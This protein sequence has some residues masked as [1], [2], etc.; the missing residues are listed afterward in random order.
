MSIRYASRVD[1][2]GQWRAVILDARSSDALST[3]TCASEAEA[4][5]AQQ[6][7][8]KEGW[9]EF[10]AEWGGKYPGSEA[11]AEAATEA[12]EEPEDE[13]P[14]VSMNLTKK[15]LLDI[16][17]DEGVEVEGDANKATILAAIEAKRAEG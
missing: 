2:A 17:E 14:A 9:S 6:W 10:P 3:V 13:A 12:E 11:E 1:A 4:D 5:E 8:F 7:A 15:A 16:A